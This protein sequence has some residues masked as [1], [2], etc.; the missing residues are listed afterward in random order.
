MENF[1]LS[2]IREFY[3]HSWSQNY[4][5][6]SDKETPE[7]WSS[8]AADFAAKVHVPEARQESLDFLQ[9][10]DWSADETVLDVAAGPGTF[11]IPLAG[12]VKEVTVT[13][14]SQ[15]MLDQLQQQAA[16]EGIANIRQLPGR[17][18]DLQLPGRYDTVLCLNSLGVI[19]ADEQRVPHLARTLEKLAEACAHRLIILIPHADSP[20]NPEM[21]QILGLDTVPLERMRVAVLYF[22][23]VD[24]GM[25]PDLH[26]I[27]RPFRWTFTSLEE[28]RET[29]LKKA[30]VKS[31][32]C[33]STE[34]D[35]Y[36]KSVIQTDANGRLTL[37]YQVSQALY[38]WTR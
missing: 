16:R 15:A 24:C 5:D 23:M 12:M 38:V 1:D 14:F 22:A 27:K 29:L 6:N 20:L 31:E 32:N 18:L 34:F 36:L 3:Q 26:I 7:F 11:A 25:L 21:R 19:S 30:G 17:W 28:A 37:A 8:R 10:F 13:D 35:A 9:R 33:N 4:G 2:R